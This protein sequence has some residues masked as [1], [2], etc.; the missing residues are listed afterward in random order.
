MSLELHTFESER[1]W[2]EARRR[3]VTSS[4]VPAILGVSTYEGGDPFS[5]WLRKTRGEG[6]DPGAMRRRFEA[7]HAM[8]PL[9]ERWFNEETGRIAFRPADGHYLCTNPAFPWAA[10]TPDLLV[11][12]GIGPDGVVE[13]K[14]LALMDRNNY[15]ASPAFLYARAQLALS[16][17]VA[18]VETGWIAAS[19][20]LGIAFNACPVGHDPALAALIEERCSAFH[21]FI[22]SGEP[23]D[24]SFISA[25]DEVT[26]AIA[27]IFDKESGETVEL[28]DRFAAM[29]KE[30]DRLTEEMR[31]LEK[32]KQALETDR[33]QIAAAFELRLGNATFGK[34]AGHDR[35]AKFT[36][37]SGGGFLMPTWERRVLRF[38]KPERATK[39]P[40]QRRKK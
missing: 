5:L 3:Y 30:Y 31:K 40:E 12:D 2:L 22:L 25:G 29:A 18:E 17:L 8:E 9:I 7:G 15:A 23:P 38:V 33:D 34:I 20:G 32:D 13:G 28:E 4:D 19:F 16:M 11:V 14:S 10:A 35:I 24:E 27:Q 1:E 6:D 36:R 37:T 21:R 26:R 39:W